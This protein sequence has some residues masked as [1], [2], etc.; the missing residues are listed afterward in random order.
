M[1][2]INQMKNL[3]IIIFLGFSNQN[4]GQSLL[5]LFLQGTWKIES[6]DDYEH[7]DKLNDKTLKGLSY[8]MQ[9]GQMKVSEYLDITDIKQ[10]IVYTA[11]VIGQNAGKD[12]AFTLRQQKDTFIFENPKHDFP[13]AIRYLPISDNEVWVSVSDGNQKSFSYRM[14]KQ[15]IQDKTVANTNYDKTLADKLGSDDYG[16]KSYFFVIL[17][18]GSNKTNDKEFIQECFRGHLNNINRLVEDGKIIIAGP[19]GKNE[20]G[21]RGIFILNNIKN[22]EDAKELL[23]TDPAIHAG[24]LDFEIFDWYGSAALPEYLPYSDKIWKVKP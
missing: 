2:H 19:T 22:I 3:F 4:F 15:N 11:S 13:K 18:T 9:A 21:Y 17:K 23:Q 1:K 5:P 8:S 20:L 10:Q 12:V 24:L 7:W 16:M 6:K 14:S